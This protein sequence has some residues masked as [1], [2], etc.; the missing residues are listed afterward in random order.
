LNIPENAADSE[1]IGII[2]KDNHFSNYTGD[3]MIDLKEPLGFRIGSLDRETA[4]IMHINFTKHVNLIYRFPDTDIRS[5]SELK[6]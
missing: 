2:I 3:G 6:G 1:E 4:E 5:T